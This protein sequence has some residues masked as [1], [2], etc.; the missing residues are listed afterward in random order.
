MET[1]VIVGDDLEQSATCTIP[2][3]Q[4]EAF[5]H[6]PSAIYRIAKPEFLDI[7]KTVAEEHLVKI[8]KEIPN[9][10][11]IYPIYQTGHFADDPRLKDFSLY[12]AQTAWNILQEQGHD[13][14]NYETYFQA[15]WCQELHKTA[16]QE[17]HIHGYGAQIIGFYFLDCPE[18]SS[19]ILI[20]DPR[21]SKKQ[22]NLP[23][24]N[25]TNATL[26]ST[27][28][29]FQPK[30]G[31]LYFT[32]AWMPHG[33]TRNS[34]NEFMRFIHFNVGIRDAQPNFQ[35]TQQNK[36][37]KSKKNSKRSGPNII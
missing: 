22:I 26:A 28:I 29:N 4:L 36:S 12:V 33:F 20:Y 34:S 19:R 21:P 23:E 5:Y 1:P 25:I 2:N 9:L 7:A 8:K 6:F 16:G 27:I 32:N 3:N 14:G 24:S 31:E 35:S 17:E 15:M 11:E 10:S 37:K 30:P 18:N 13:M